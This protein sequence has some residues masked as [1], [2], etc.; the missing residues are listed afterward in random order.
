MSLV[1]FLVLAVVGVAALAGWRRGLVAQLV[2]FSGVLLGAIVG[3]RV[4]PLFLSGGVESPWV[5]LASLVG[6]LIGAVLLQTLTS[7]LGTS[8]R[9]RIVPGPMRIVDSAGGLAT[10]ALV[11]LGVMWLLAVLAI[12][13]PAIGLRSQ[14]ERSFVMAR[15][16]DRVPA[17]TILAALESLDPLPLLSGVPYA[18]LP[19]PDPSVIDIELAHSSYPSVVEINGTS[20][21]VRAQGS[22]WVATE[23]LVVT[24]A[25]VVAGQHDTRILVPSGESLP[26][27]IVYLDA[28]NDVAVL[29]APGLDAPAL[30]LAR[31]AA[32]G[33]TV[34]LLGYPRGG[35]LQ[36]DYATA[37]SPRK[38]IAPDALN[39]TRGFRTVVPLRAAVEPGESG[40]PVINAEGHVVSMIFGST[41]DSQG[42]VGVPLSAI[43]DA[44]AADLRR[45]PAGACV[46]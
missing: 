12:Q 42:S 13:Q 29:H 18:S 16:V 36:A 24:N 28:A 45:V 46:R 2:S 31:R 19:A 15:L 37:G 7:M 11:G 17:R 3:S 44:L 21:G 40:G 41:E 9:R 30:P 43:R 8:M 27:D 23:T 32:R 33:E 35:P 1:D 22:G 10:G 4:A 38:V 26:A 25:H 6:A 39:R 14:V 5:P 34:V 20:C